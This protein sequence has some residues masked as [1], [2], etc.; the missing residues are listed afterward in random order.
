MVQSSLKETE[1]Y[2]FGRVLT[3]DTE[4]MGDEHLCDVLADRDG[5]L[6]HLL[7]CGSQSSLSGA[8]VDQVLDPFFVNADNGAPKELFI[9]STAAVPFIR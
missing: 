6:G 2:K 4:L 5:L 1:R 8:V 3:F 9:S 7:D